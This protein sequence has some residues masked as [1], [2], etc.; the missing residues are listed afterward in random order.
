MMTFAVLSVVGVV[1]FFAVLCIASSVL[2][3][4][5]EHVEDRD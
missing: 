5:T 3:R 2:E 1:G 4:M